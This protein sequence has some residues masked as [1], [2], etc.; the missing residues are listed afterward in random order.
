MS[1]HLYR[2]SLNGTSRFRRRSGQVSFL[3]LLFAICNGRRSILI[4]AAPAE[5]WNEFE[6]LDRIQSW[7]GIGQTAHQFNLS[8]GGEVNLS[9][10]IDGDARHFGGAIIVLDAEQE[11]TF[12]SQWQSPYEWPVP[13][14]WTIRLTPLYDGTHV[15]IIHHGFERFGR[16][17]ADNL[18]SYEEGWTV[19]HLK[20]LRAIVEATE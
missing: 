20:A 14:F 2:V 5:I 3:I 10:D 12:E 13:T 7:L 11:V 8:P 4:N 6:T 19:N 9:V 15:E 17:A 18:Q 1:C 16:D